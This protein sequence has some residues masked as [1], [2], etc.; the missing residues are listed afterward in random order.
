MSAKPLVSVCIQTYQHRNFIAAAIDSVLSQQ[1]DF[2]WEIIIGEDDSTDGTRE[3]CQ[4]YAAK[5]PGLIRLFLRDEKDKIFI[6]GKMTGRFNFLSNLKE[7]R[8]Q[9]IA[10]LDGDDCWTSNNKLQQQ[11]EMFRTHPQMALCTHR[12]IKQLP[13]GRTEL[14]L[15][16]YWKETAAIYPSSSLLKEYY[17]FM[18]AVMFPASNIN[19]LPAWFWELPFIDYALMIYLS[20]FGDIGYLPGIMTRYNVH[21]KGMWSAA[22][23]PENKIRL[24][25]ALT[26]MALHMEGDYQEAMEKGRERTGHDLVAYYRTHAWKNSVWFRKELATHRFAFD[27]VLLKDLTKTRTPLEFL[28]N[29]GNGAKDFARQMLRI[30]RIR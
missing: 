27:S 24:W 23:E 1:T 9:Y 2:E 18:S 13:G 6:R 20:R 30:L 8:G 25:D 29:I 3:I 22:R 15:S 16:A 12:Y 26:L 4:S 5:Y 28:Q 10:L 7:A 19:N 17:V 11:V 21:S 14:P